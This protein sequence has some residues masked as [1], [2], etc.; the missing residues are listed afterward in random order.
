MK[1]VLRPEAEQDVEEAF[2]RYA[3][4]DLRLARDFVA[5]VRDAISR[6]ARGR[7]SFPR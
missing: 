3:E 5:A 6:F 7:F 2:G 4:K 1:V